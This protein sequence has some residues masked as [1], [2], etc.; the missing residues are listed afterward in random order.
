M[1]ISAG[2]AQQKLKEQ[3][4]KRQLANIRNVEQYIQDVINNAIEHE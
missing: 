2:Q 4:E 3:Q 1:I